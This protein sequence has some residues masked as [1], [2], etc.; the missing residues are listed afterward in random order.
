MSQIIVTRHALR[1][2]AERIGP[3]GGA[4]VRRSARR[5][6]P[7]PPHLARAVACHQGPSDQPDTAVLVDKE[8][9]VV[10]LCD[11]R[12]HR[13]GGRRVG[14]TVITVLRLDAVGVAT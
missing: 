14:L 8:A 3:G 12:P 6:R 9:G 2:W 10:L 1:R 11:P 5:A 13:G 4:A 7:A